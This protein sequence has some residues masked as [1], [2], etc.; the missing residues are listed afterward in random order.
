VTVPVVL[1]R[2]RRTRAPVLLLLAGA[3]LGSTV[4]RAQPFE[5]DLQQAMLTCAEIETGTARLECF[6]AL[7]LRLRS[8]ATGRAGPREVSASIL[9]LE[10]RPHGERVFHLS[11]GQVWTELEA[12]RARYREGLAVRIEQT[13]FGAYMLSSAAGRA[14]RVRR[15]E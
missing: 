7:A 6:D 1:I 12:G 15:L 5:Q 11:N 4:G 8:E 2:H 9:R 10:Q 13:T 14:T 3:L